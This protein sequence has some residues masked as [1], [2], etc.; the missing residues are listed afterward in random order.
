MRHSA[1][2]QN[3]GKV[4]KRAYFS[5][6]LSLRSKYS[7]HHLAFHLIRRTGL[8]PIREG[9]NLSILAVGYWIFSTNVRGTTSRGSSPFLFLRVGMDPMGPM[10]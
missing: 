10:R 6:L 1:Q 3:M 4:S 5:R 2:M 9:S 8:N 7:V